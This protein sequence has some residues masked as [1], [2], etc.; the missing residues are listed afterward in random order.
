MPKVLSHTPVWLSRPS[1]GYH[2]FEPTPTATKDIA[3]KQESTGLR[4]NIAIR[5][6]EVFVAVGRELRWADLAQLKEDEAPVSRKLNVPMPLPIERLTISP[7][8]DYLAVSTSHT[9]H[10][11]CLPDASLLA[12]G[13]D[14]AIKPKT[15]QIGPVAH[16][17]EESPIA[18]VLWHPL[19]YHGHCLVTITLEGVVRLWEI[20]RADRSTFSEPTLSIDLVKLA[21]AQNY[22]VNLSASSYGASKGFSPDMADLEV[23]SA[24]FGDFPDQEGVHGWAPVT[25]W[26]AT[27]AGGVYALCP[28]LPSKWQLLESPGASTFL[29]TLSSSIDVHHADISEDLDASQYEKV[30]ADKQL[31]WKSDIVYHEPLEEV[32]PNGD[33]VKVFP[34]PASVPAVPALQGPFEIKPD[35]DDYELSDIVVY[36]LKTFSD[37]DEDDQ[38]AEGLPAAVVCLLT[39][40]CQVHVCFDILGITGCWLP[41]A[42]DECRPEE[43]KHSLVLA[44]TI[45]LVN[46]DVSSNKQNITQ[47]VHTDFS[48]FV[49]HS[50]GVFYISLE[51]WIR[52]VETELA[53]NQ[54]DGATFR[55]GKLLEGGKTKVEKCLH[56][57]AGTAGKEITSCVV[58]EDGN[59]GYLLITTVDN[60][61]QAVI[62]DAPE[63]DGLPDEEELLQRQQITFPT[64]AREPWNPPKELWEPFDL[65]AALNIPSRQK[66]SL[67]DEIRL[68]PANLALLMNAHRV[69]AAHTEK[70]QHAV[71]DLFNRCQ[72]LQDEYRDQIWRTAQLAPK[73]DAAT[74]DDENTDSIAHLSSN[75]QIE[76]RLE[77]AKARQEELNARYQALRRKAAGINTTEISEKEAAFT[78]ELQTMES[79]IDRTSQY[80]TDDVDG[81]EVPAWQR[82][83]KVKEMKAEL[84]EE[85]EKEALTNGNG[86]QEREKV[87]RARMNV[88]SHS[89]KLE[90]EQVQL[91]LQHQADLL[92]ATTD[93][94]RNLGIP[95]QNVAVDGG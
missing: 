89:R 64:E 23:A 45:T 53:Q 35:V 14:K 63:D 28:L 60:E 2:L 46:D 29:Q 6:S 27:I 65:F 76:S 39:D 91:M 77:K 25:L 1:P 87:L 19:S 80:L 72:R 69:L 66:S 52:G 68:S 21:T 33:T 61:P 58:V 44:E 43:S 86:D 85:V 50:S 10:V 59:V 34:R 5:D 20:N 8:G 78:S 73:I 15:F 37:G 24:C 94:L 81:S 95:I 9:V 12:P 70:L 75:G 31:S 67:N 83:E 40:T 49:T 93:R 82:L 38:V 42:E 4:R 22:D 36:S 84:V 13:D 55:C 74:G 32:L 92:E 71:S 57:Q 48:F 17:L 56:R 11:V 18:S 16:V 54:S 7:A 3:R 62:L 26:I 90:N 79:S 51:S 41:L 47:D 88:P 30:T